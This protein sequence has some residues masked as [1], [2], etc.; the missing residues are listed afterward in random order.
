VG[1][2]CGG[3]EWGFREVEPEKSILGMRLSGGG[4]AGAGKKGVEGLGGGSMV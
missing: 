4:S 2:G 3:I 1:G